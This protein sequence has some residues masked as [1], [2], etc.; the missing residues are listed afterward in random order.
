MNN[1]STPEKHRIEREEFWQECKVVVGRIPGGI[2][3]VGMVEVK[4]RQVTGE[5]DTSNQYEFKNSKDSFLLH[6][7]NGSDLL[8]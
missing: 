7:T 8:R 5:V 3:V 6:E 1:I 4:L 2:L